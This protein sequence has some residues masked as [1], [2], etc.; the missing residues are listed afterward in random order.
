M[1]LTATATHATFEAV[2]QRLSLQD[3]LLVSVSPNRQNI[4]LAVSPHIPLEM[5]VEKIS[6]DLKIAKKGYPKTIVFCQTYQNCTDL[7]AELI[8]D[9]GKDKTDPTGYPNLI[10]Y[11]LVTM[12]TRASTTDMKKQVLSLFTQASSTLCIVIAMTAFSMGIDCHDIHQVIHWARAPA[13]LEQYLQEI[14]RAGRDG[15]AS[16]ALLICGK[17]NNHVQ[18]QMKQYY[19]NLQS[20]RRRKLFEL[21]IAYD[22]TNR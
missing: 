13:D 9:L 22:I 1:A 16:K 18:Y 14:G 2:K 5:L 17:R 20:C 4:F 10:Q 12:Y 15:E 6:T 19:E 7:Y 11:R 3:P 21:F 8:H